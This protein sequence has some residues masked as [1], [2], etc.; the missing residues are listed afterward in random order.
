MMETW[1]KKER[2]ALTFK[3]EFQE[4]EH[5]NILE[6]RGVVAVLRHLSRS[7]RS[8]G[9]RI[10]CFT[11]SLVTL[12]A[13]GKGRSSARALLR[14]CRAAAAVQLLC[15]IKLYLRWVPSERNFADGPSRGG[16]VGVDQHTAESHNDR[17]MPRSL[18]SW[19]GKLRATRARQP[20]RAPAVHL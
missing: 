16:P 8:W 1:L 18:R 15:R 10:L 11:D 19:L 5:N 9:K 2:W 14:L 17:G 12:G 3:G 4:D 6:M 7:S 20:E 13:L